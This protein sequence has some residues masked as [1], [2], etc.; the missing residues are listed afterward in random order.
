MNKTIPIAHIYQESL[1]HH[2][3]PDIGCQAF[4]PDLK[5]AFKGAQTTR[6]KPMATRMPD[7]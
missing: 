4:T 5:A 6:I 7:K 3:K 2:L 1:G